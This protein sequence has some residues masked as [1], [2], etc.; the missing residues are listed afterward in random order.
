M[1]MYHTYL[2]SFDVMTRLNDPGDASGAS[3]LE[4]PYHTTLE[5]LMLDMLLALSD[6]ARLP[7]R[8]HHICKYACASWAAL[9]AQ[10]PKQLAAI[11]K[12]I[13]A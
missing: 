8:V 9:G 3:L 12:V 10:R 1:S 2:E 11:R 4:L 6:S 13:L 7:L 5:H